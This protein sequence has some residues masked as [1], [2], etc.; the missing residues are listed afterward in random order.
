[1]ASIDLTDARVLV[2]GGSGV[3]GG[4]IARQL[5][6]RKARVALSGRDEAKLREN[7]VAIGAISRRLFRNVAGHGWPL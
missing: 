2:L 3:L 5:K 6:D 4:E 1:V 7:A